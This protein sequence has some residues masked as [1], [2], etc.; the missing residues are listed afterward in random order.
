MAGKKIITVFGATG[1]Q[2]G[3]VVDIFLNDPKLKN[4]WSVRAVTRDITK[5]SA[6]KLAAQGAEVV[7]NVSL[8]RFIPSPATLYRMALE[9]SCNQ[10]AARAGSSSG[11]SRQSAGRNRLRGI[12][13]DLP[14]PAH[15]RRVL[16]LHPVCGDGT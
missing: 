10:Y 6:K 1:Q 2:G 8:F 7:Q 3:S 13:S 12:G 15:G 9:C 4:E 14:W 11:R 5:E 16:T